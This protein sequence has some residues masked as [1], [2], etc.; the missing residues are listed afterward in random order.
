[1]EESTQFVTNKTFSRKF[2]SIETTLEE[3]MKYMQ[4]MQ[5]SIVKMAQSISHIGEQLKQKETEINNGQ[6]QELKSPPCK[7]KN[8]NQKYRSDNGTDDMITE[9]TPQKHHNPKKK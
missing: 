1:M 6:Q 3:N 5:E 9:E 8:R 7:K 2:S 4:T